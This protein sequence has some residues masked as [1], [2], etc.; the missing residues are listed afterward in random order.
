MSEQIKVIVLSEPIIAYGE[1]VKQLRIR[2][3]TTAD[4]RAIG[5]LPYAISSDESVHL[6]LGVCAKYLVRLADIPLSAVDQISL[7]EFHSISW[8]IAQSF[9]AGASEAKTE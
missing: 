2:E 4:A 9:L 8:E 3:V 6:N 1:E 5:S 7:A